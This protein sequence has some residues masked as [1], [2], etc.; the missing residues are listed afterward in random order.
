[1]TWSGGRVNP[2][3]WTHGSAAAREYWFRVGYTKG[4]FDACDTFKAGN[5]HLDG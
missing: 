1:M 3:Q 4:D 2:D 5:L